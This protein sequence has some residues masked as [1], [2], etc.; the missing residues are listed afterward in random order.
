MTFKYKFRD[1]AQ[2]ASVD[3]FGF[4]FQTVDDAECI[5]S[6]V[7]AIQT[8]NLVSVDTPSLLTTVWKSKLRTT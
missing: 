5:I 1:T 6:C 4:I 3:D 7:F 8:I 2:A